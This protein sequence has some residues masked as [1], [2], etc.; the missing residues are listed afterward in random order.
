[1]T[2]VPPEL[3]HA[4][5]DLQP[6]AVRFAE[7]DGKH[8]AM[9]N[10]DRDRVREVAAGLQQLIREMDWPKTGAAIPHEVMGN[11]LPKAKPDSTAD[12]LLQVFEKCSF[13]EGKF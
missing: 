12:S 2:L 8:G 4:L 13:Q 10:E 3:K 7:H 11:T 6:I 9:T 1:M 5:A